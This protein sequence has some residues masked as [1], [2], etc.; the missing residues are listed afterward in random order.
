MMW[1]FST[2]LTPLQSTG[3]GKLHQVDQVVTR[4]KRPQP[5]IHSEDSTKR[6]RHSRPK[7][8]E[9]NPVFLYRSL[10]Q[11]LLEKQRVP[12]RQRSQPNL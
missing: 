2:F 11:K 1:K 12:C 8:S 10:A 5:L 7:I 3:N 9:E 4:L 6:H